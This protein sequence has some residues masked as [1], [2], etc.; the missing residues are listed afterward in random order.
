MKT[1]LK[2]KK[3]S[4]IKTNGRAKVKVNG[5]EMNVSDIPAVRYAFDNDGFSWWLTQDPADQSKI[6]INDDV[7]KLV[8]IAKAELPKS[9][10]IVEL[11]LWE[12]IDLAWE[13]QQIREKVGKVAIF[14]YVDYD[15]DLNKLVGNL[16]TIESVYG[17]IDRLL[18]RERTED[19][20]GAEEVNEIIDL[21]AGQVGDAKAEKIGMC[22]SP[23]GCSIGY[24]CLSAALCRHLSAKYGDSL[25]MV[26]PSQNHEGMSSSAE[27]VCGCICWTLVETFE[28]LEA[29]AVSKES[30]SDEKSEQSAKKKP[31]GSKKMVMRW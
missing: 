24:S 10:H 29:K 25:D 11:G 5:Q 17:D 23:V 2:F 22:D 13:I 3:P 8:K 7:C 28:A 6:I 16:D 20:L 15:G 30:S 4:L 14:V 9:L 31:A 27:N 26:V 12:N 21:A 1:V 18:I 19:C